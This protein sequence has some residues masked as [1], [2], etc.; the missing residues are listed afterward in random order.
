M[1]N[2]RKNLF[3]RLEDIYKRRED[4]KSKGI[5]L[6]RLVDTCLYEDISE[7]TF[8]KFRRIYKKLTNKQLEN[9]RKG[10]IGITAIYNDMFCS[11]DCSDKEIVFEEEKKEEFYLK[12]NRED[13]NSNLERAISVSRFILDLKL[14]ANDIEDV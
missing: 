5:E 11:C 3:C 10:I 4:L 6:P 2:C 13:L 14:Q 7:N 12:V 9:L 8:Y 1:R